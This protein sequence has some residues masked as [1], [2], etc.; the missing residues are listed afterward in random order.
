MRSVFSTAVLGL[1]AATAFLAVPGVSALSLSEESAAAILGSG[2]ECQTGFNFGGRGLTAESDVLPLPPLATMGIERDPATGFG[3]E[4]VKPDV[5]ALTDGIYTSMFAVTDEGVVLFDVP[6]TLAPGIL[7][8][9]ASVS[10]KKVSHVIYSHHHRDHISGYGEIAADLPIEV[11]IIASQPVATRL[12]EFM[13]SARPGPTMTFEKE[14]KL[15]IGGLDIELSVTPGGHSQGNIFIYLPQKQVAMVV[16]IIYPGFVPF[17]SQFWHTQFNGYQQTIDEFLEFD[18]DKYV[19]GHLN[20]VGTRED[21]L[22]AKEFAA[23]VLQ[24]ATDALS[25]QPPDLPPLA[26]INMELFLNSGGNALLAFVGI[27]NIQIDTCYSLLEPKWAGTLG[28]FDV[29]TRFH[30]A[31]VLIYIQLINN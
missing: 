16:D 25:T 29:M 22:N 3:L 26:E 19:L 8:A 15:S 11:E 30:C 23:D 6:L 28:S 5:Y 21:V 18:A 7:D 24:A 13:D 17:R 10:D 4:E 2:A 12:A 20:R 1:T 14:M 27:E 31:N 9:V